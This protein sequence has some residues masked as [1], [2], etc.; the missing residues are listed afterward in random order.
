MLAAV[1]TARIAVAALEVCLV[2][3]GGVLMLLRLLLMTG[4]AIVHSR[5]CRAREPRRWPSPVSVVVPAFNESRTIAAT[6]RSLAAATIRWRSSWWTTAPPTTPPPSSSG[7][8]LPNVRVMRK[9]DGGKPSAL[10]AGVAASRHDIVVMMDGDS[11][12]EPT[13]VGRLVAPFADPQVG[14]V[15]GN[16]RVADRRSLIARWQNIEYVVGFNIDRRVQ[17]VWRAV[18]TVPGA[19][20]AFRRSALLQVGGRQRRDAR[21]GHRPHHRA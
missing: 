4:G 9:P 12:F 20:G 14:A 8:R 16:A 2:V 11:V 7:S 17:D 3:V 13:T 21:R 5:R 10:N 15:A 19:V 1:A 18:T 6:V